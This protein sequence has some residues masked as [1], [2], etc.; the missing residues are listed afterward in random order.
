MAPLQQTS[1]LGYCAAGGYAG[2]Y[3]LAKYNK[4]EGVDLLGYYELS[5]TLAGAA[6]GYIWLLA[7]PGQVDTFTLWKS[8]A[9]GAVSQWV[10]NKWL[11]S[12]FM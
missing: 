12:Y 4:V 5:S 10:W 3:A 2:A 1:Y 7:M 6:G 9:V 8:L 11:A